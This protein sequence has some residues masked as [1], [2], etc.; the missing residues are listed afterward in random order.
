MPFNF[1][2]IMGNIDS[3]KFSNLKVVK[4]LRKSLKKSKGWVSHI[5]NVTLVV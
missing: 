2:I 3:L 5:R 4:D 1:V